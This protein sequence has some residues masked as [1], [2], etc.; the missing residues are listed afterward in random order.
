MQSHTLSTINLGNDNV[1]EK[2]SLSIWCRRAILIA[3]DQ[4][5]MSY[6]VISAD[7]Y[8]TAADFFAQK[9]VFQLFK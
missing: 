3:Y 1:K 4:R 9:T 2:N 7:F 6:T 5:L 8:T